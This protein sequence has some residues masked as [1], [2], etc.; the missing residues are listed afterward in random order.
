M[1]QFKFNFFWGIMAVSIISSCDKTIALPVLPKP[2][3]K[4]D[5][6]TYSRWKLVA[7]GFDK[8]K[9]GTID[10]D[11]TPPYP[12]FLDNLTFFYKDGHGSFDQGPTKCDPDHAQSRRF[13]WNFFNNESMV[14][15]DAQEY[16]ILSLT[17]T[18]FVITYEDIFTP[19]P[20]NYILKLT[21]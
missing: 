9:D 11:E 16:K 21:H 18:D 13:E 17:E 20:N 10:L 19:P 6:L 12:C 4:T 2:I 8:N 15:I 3:T 5:M 7:E 14:I 1:K